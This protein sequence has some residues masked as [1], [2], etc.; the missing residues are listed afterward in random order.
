MSMLRSTSI[1]ALLA[2]EMGT[3]AVRRAQALRDRTLTELQ[4][5]AASQLE[6]SG[7]YRDLYGRPRH[8]GDVVTPK[9]FR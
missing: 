3:P 6:R 7:S 4:P 2:Q 1:P 8:D 9:D 5:D